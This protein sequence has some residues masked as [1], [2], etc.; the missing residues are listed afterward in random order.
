MKRAS[1]A[2]I[3]FLAVVGALRGADAE[4]SL[5]TCYPGSE[6]YE[7]DGHSA[8][9]VRSD[10]FDVVFSW[11]VFDFNAPNFLYRFVKGETDY[12]LAEIPFPYFIADYIEQGRKVVE[13]P[14]QLTPSQQAKLL[15]SLSVNLRPEN[16]VYRYNYVKD[17]CA[18]RPMRLIS[19][20]GAA[21]FTSCYVSDDRTF[22]E[23]MRTYHR[24]YPWYQFGIDLALGSGIDYAISPE[25]QAFSP[26][27]L[28]RML[29]VEPAVLLEG[30]DSG[31]VL[32]PTPRYLTPMS[33]FLLVFVAVLCSCVIAV[34]RGSVIKWVYSAFYGAMGVTGCVM[35]FL[36]FVSVHEA[37]SP[38][39]LFLFF[40]PFC[41]IPAIFIWAKRC[42]MLVVC[43]QFVN[44]A[45]IIGGSALWP[46][47]GQS[48]N[49]AVIPILA[50]DICLSVTY[51]YINYKHRAIDASTV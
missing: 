12:R 2:V 31:A 51:L 40:N 30:P 18:T 45:L 43:Y 10:S 19:R 38:N 36:I 39:W 20:S 13:Q 9:R 28:M 37:T 14:L 24:N 25:E 46:L 1:L 6:V 42:R 48:M 33:V 21:T 15:S 44:F 41:L 32:G 5:L 4:V 29:D 17:N 3:F 7:L 22:R 8:L 26:M 35:A 27:L 34:R 11:G 47:T 49:A 23:V 50:A 16:L